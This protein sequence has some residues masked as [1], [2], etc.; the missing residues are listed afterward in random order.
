M[1]G[2]AKYIPRLRVLASHEDGSRDG[3]APRRERASGCQFT[4]RRHVAGRA[5]FGERI[6]VGCARR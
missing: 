2:L 5:P 3:G 6:L 4:R 1:N